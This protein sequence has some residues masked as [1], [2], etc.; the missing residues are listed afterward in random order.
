[1]FALPPL[2]GAEVEATTVASFYPNARILIGRRA[3]KRAFL[4]EMATSNVVH[5]AGHGVVRTDAPLLSYLVLAADGDSEASATLTAQD[6][7]GVRLSKT[8]LAILSGCQTAGGKISDTEGASSLARALFGAGVPAVVASLWAVDDKATAE[9]FTA[10]HRRLSKGEDPTAALRLT[11]KE[12]LTRTSDPWQSVST[13]A[14]FAL[15]GATSDETK[16]AF[17]VATRQQ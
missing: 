16:S 8:R 15:F 5:F 11:Q 2:P 7:F 10:Y 6:L 9:F 1:M 12:W 4:T 3:T 17:G 14:A 13:W